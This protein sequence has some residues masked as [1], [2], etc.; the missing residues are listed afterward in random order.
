MPELD[1]L[2]PVGF[3][4]YVEALAGQW[5]A[6]LGV[7]VECK[8]VSWDD[9]RQQKQRELPHLWPELW[10][11]DYPDPDNFLR[12]AMHQLAR[13]WGNP[14]YDGLVERARRLADQ[15]QRMRL[16][17]EADRLLIQ[18]AVIMPLA[19]WQEHKLIKP[20]VSRFP[21][22]PPWEHFWKDVVIE[23]H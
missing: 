14:A 5:R 8:V 6:N 2:A 19:Y 13:L 10:G 15:A 12:L 11:A 21:T 22:T 23:A 20:W 18:E 3:D 4:P 16:Y 7:E 1:A 9:F 17:N